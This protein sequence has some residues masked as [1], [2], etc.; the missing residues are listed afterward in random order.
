MDQGICFPADRRNP[1]QEI[2][3]EFP[4]EKAVYASFIIQFGFLNKYDGR[5]TL[6]TSIKEKQAH[7]LERAVAYLKS[8]MP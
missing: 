1:D 4:C 8:P 6:P 7:W 3:F 2:V 5:K